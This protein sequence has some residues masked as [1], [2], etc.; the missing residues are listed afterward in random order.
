[1]LDLYSGGQ[2]LEM[3]I[4]DSLSEYLRHVQNGDEIT[5]LDHKRPVAKVIPI[6][7][8]SEPYRLTSRA[9]LQKGFRDIRPNVKI[10]IDPADYVA[11]DREDRLS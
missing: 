9:P 5:I 3:C 2:T 11:Q 1:M 7:P 6:T 10:D 8:A 4:R